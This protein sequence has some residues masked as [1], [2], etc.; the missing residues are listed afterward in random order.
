MT[1]L[2]KH[3]NV[4]TLNLSLKEFIN[5]NKN[6]HTQRADKTHFLDFKISLTSDS[7]VQ[8]FSKEKNRG[9]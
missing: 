2:C 8:V 6:P 5:E 4:V 9:Y 7:R 3:F 1:N